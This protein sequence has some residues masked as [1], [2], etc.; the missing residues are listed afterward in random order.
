MVLTTTRD[1]I[2]IALL[3]A[4]TLA[5]RVAAADGDSSKYV[6]DPADPDLEPV[7][8]ADYRAPGH[9][10]IGFDFGV[11]VL[12]GTCSGCDRGLGGL[13]LDVF[14]G[15]QLTPRLAVVGDLWTI[16]H[17]LPADSADSRGVATHTFATAA[18]R[19]WALPELW[20]QAGVGGAA[21][22][23]DGSREDQSDLAPAFAVSIGGEV[24]HRPTRSIALTARLGVGRY[25]D[26]DGSPTTLYNIA[27]VVGWHW[28]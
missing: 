24:E 5:P 7:Y 10:A 27:A 23:V 22:R 25:E 28:Y 18:A 12:G 21:F 9:L 20:L 14:A 13:A 15:A 26:D 16:I 3:T 8:V 2:A 6:S 19:F 11:G 1:A 4:V 17:L